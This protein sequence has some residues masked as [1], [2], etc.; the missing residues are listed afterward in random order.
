MIFIIDKQQRNFMFYF[1]FSINCN[2]QQI[3]GKTIITPACMEIL[4][5]ARVGRKQ[6]K[7]ACSDVI[8][9]KQALKQATQDIFGECTERN[10]RQVCLRCKIPLRGFVQSK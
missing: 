2:R 1:L 6:K 9:R 3:A 7:N 10:L 5:R 4:C 8:S